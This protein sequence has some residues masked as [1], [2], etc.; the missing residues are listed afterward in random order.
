MKFL[1]TLKKTKNHKRDTSKSIFERVLFCIGCLVIFFIPIEHKYDK[2]LRHFSAKIIPENFDFGSFFDFNI[3]FYPSDI[4]ML[5]I[6]FSMIFCNKSN[7]SIFKNHN[8]ILYVFF[9][10]VFLSILTSPLSGYLT[11]YTRFLGIFT[12]IVVY[13]LFANLN[14]TEGNFKTVFLVFVFAALIQS[15]IACTQYFSQEYLG[16]RIIGETKD[17][18]AFFKNQSGN[19]W[20][21]DLVREKSLEYF[22]IRRASGTFSNCNPLGG[23]LALGCLSVYPFLFRRQNFCY[24]I[25]SSMVLFVIFFSLCLTFSRSAI[26]GLIVATVIWFSRLYFAFKEVGQWSTLLKTILFSFAFSFF[27]LFNQ[28]IARGG[29]INY[30]DYSQKAD[31]ARISAAKTAFLMILDAPFSGVGFQQYSIAASKL[32]NSTGVHNMFL[33]VTAESGVFS[34][35]F[36]IAFFFYILKKGLSRPFNPIVDTFVAMLICLLVI[37]SLDFYPIL[38]QQGRLMTFV[39]CGCVIASANYFNNRAFQFN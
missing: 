26:L 18:L 28:L 6:F 14:F 31:I 35:I 8:W 11:V 20:T 30:T 23:F 19:L 21:L 32:G 37:G 24:K 38:F 39:V 1:R 27:L 7:F 22:K 12:A 3:Y 5:L 2:L 15:V 13:F 34:G 16:L 10:L 29:L 25:V 17:A 4:F 33:F 36:L 9:I